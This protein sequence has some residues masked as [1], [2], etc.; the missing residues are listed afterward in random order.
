VRKKKEK[1]TNPQTSGGDQA[2]KPQQPEAKVKRRKRKHGGA[3]NAGGD[4]NANDG[5][6]A[7]NDQVT[8]TVPMEA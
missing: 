6:A 2:D 1:P 8:A 7:G 3:K 5:E 4:G